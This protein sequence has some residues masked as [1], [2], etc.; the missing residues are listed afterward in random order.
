MKI[1]KNKFLH[2]DSEYRGT[3][4]RFLDVVS[5]CVICDNI[6]RN[7]WVY[8]DEKA[9][10]RLKEF[11]LSKKDYIFVC[12]NAVAEGQFLISIGLDPLDFKWI[13]L[14][15]E[16][17]MLVNNWDRLGYGPQLVD[18]KVKVT[19]RSPN[20]WSAEA[21]IDNGDHDRT[22]TSL[23]AAC[24]K[25]LNIQI[26]TEHKD[27]IRDLILFSKHFTEEDKAEIL[28][29]GESDTI[30]LESMLN[31]ILM[32]QR[33]K[34]PPIT[35]KDRL[36]RGRV[37]AA[38]SKMTSEGYPVDV[39]KILVFQKNLPYA[40]MD[41]CEDINSQ[42]SEPI[43]VWDS[44]NQRYS[45]LQKRVKELV[46]AQYPDLKLTW[47]KTKTGAISLETKNLKEM[48]GIKHT[49]KENDLVHQLVR[50]KDFE[51]HTKSL[52][53][54]AIRGK[55]F[56]EAVGDDGRARAWLN[57]YGA[58]TGRFQ[59]KSSHFL[60]LKPAWSRILCKPKKGRVVLGTD[61]VSQEFLL[62]GCVSL[63]F[64]V[65]GAYDSGDVYLAFGK[66]AKLI[67]PEGTK[68]THKIKRNAS[69]QAVL[70]IG[71]GMGEKSLAIRITSEA[72]PTTV[73]QAKGFIDSYFAVFSE[74]KKYR[75]NTYIQYKRTGY[76]KA[77]DGWV[78]YGDQDNRN[79]ILNFP[80]QSAGSAIL[81]AAILMCYEEGLTPII[82]LHDALYIESNIETWKEDLIKLNKILRRAS[83]LFFEGKAKEWAE[84][85]RLES[86]AW[87]PDLTNGFIELDGV[88]VDI[89]P[90][91]IDE[92]GALELK[93]YEKYFTELSKEEI[94]R[95]E[96]KIQDLSAS[97]KKSKIK[98]IKSKTGE[99]LLLLPVF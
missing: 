3:N 8:D 65:K 79:S 15:I 49:Y 51:K 91:Y 72:E 35:L 38:T 4:Q 53:A 55:N 34:A 18:G 76:L 12:F 6:T 63:D 69:K 36:Y 27:R 16:Y 17:K 43:F 98:K 87:G 77:I 81:R 9:K 19:S 7:F 48:F 11:F 61:F 71:Y 1:T 84:S 20:K 93:K 44:K 22:Q 14:Q 26:N 5:A 96:K 90:E 67:P 59:P 40:T 97:Y 57:P 30:Y 95:Y 58:Q 45:M 56:M 74:Y 80:L 68:E 33:E 83:G 86:V 50:Y 42:L 54:T 46:E 39:E 85:V 66:K 37:G 99:Q 28:K 24:Y 92:R 64:E 82:P 41:L 29:Y 94:G 2:F 10:T 25:L 78:M 23:A 31:K 13:D 75:E 89:M 47:K 21:L 52:R 60:F 70:G 62:Q 88:P 73:D 32:L